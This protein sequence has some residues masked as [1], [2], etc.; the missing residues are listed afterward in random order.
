MPRVD[1]VTA[2]IGSAMIGTGLYGI[3]SPA[4]MARFFGI[5]DVTPDMAFPFTAIGGRNLSAGLGIWGL[6]LANQR[7]A[8]GIVLLSW[9]CAGFADTYLLLSHWAAV[10]QV[11]VHVFNTCV[12]A[13]A[14]AALLV[15]K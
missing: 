1:I 6:K 3:L 2:I 11:R 8:L 5:V 9:T 15:E 13:F 14:A 7:R 4:D 10:D 12:L